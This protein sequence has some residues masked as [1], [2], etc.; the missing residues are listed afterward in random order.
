MRQ[1][2][3]KQGASGQFLLPIRRKAVAGAFQNR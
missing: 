1:W 3:L 2:R